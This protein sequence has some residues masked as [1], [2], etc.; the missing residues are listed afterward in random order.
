MKL[1]IALSE[2]ASYIF[3]FDF[4]KSFVSELKNSIWSFFVLSFVYG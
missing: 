4:L 3:L 1:K 2:T